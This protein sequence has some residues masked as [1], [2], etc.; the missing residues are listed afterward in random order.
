MQLLEFEVHGFKSLYNCRLENLQPINVF[1]GENNVGKSN[2]LEAMELFFRTVSYLALN[3]SAPPVLPLQEFQKRFEHG[4]EVFSWNG[5][6]KILLRGHLAQSRIRLAH[7]QPIVIAIE[8]ALDPHQRT[9]SV[10]LDTLGRVFLGRPPYSRNEVSSKDRKSLFADFDKLVRE[11][12]QPREFYRVLARRRLTEEFVETGTSMR[13]AQL[14]PLDPAGDNLKQWLFWAWNSSD[15]KERRAFEQ[16]LRPVFAEPPFSYGI[17]RPVARPGEPYDLQLEAAD[18]SIPIDQLGSGI[19]QL[20]LLGGMI[21]LSQ[22]WIVAIE[23]PEINL[24]W[25]SQKKLQHILQHMV[26]DATN[27]PTQFFLSSHSPVFQ[28]FKQYFKV[29]M[30]D[31]KTT[32]DPKLNEQQASEFTTISEGRG[33]TIRNGKTVVYEGAGVKLRSGNVVVL[34]EHVLEALGI[35]EGDAVYFHREGDRML[36]LNDAQLDELLKP[37]EH[38]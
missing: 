4:T 2:L 34:P 26:D 10:E 18:R 5:D 22:S 6:N 27:A 14:P 33:T 20:A 19:Q 31:G 9:I 21:A 37:Q 29:E 11:G 25:T 32:I 3:P 23:E 16:V 7:L 36:M 24:S 15:P 38:K 8:F 1:H 17:L 28:F 30:K 13:P 35:S 12:F